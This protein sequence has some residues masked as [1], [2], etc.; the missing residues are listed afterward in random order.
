M[1]DEKTSLDLA[2]QISITSYENAMKRFDAIDNKIQ[3]LFTFALGFLVIT[4]SLIKPATTSLTCSFWVAIALLVVAAVLSVLARLYGKLHSLSPQT[5]FNECL[6]L[7]PDKFKREV[8]ESAGKAYDENKQM[9][10]T[11]WRLSLASMTIFGAGLVC[12]IYWLSRQM[13]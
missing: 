11:K 9:L 5:I 4:P 8:I 10:E 2:Y 6:A 1:A 3:N 12:L 7:E 13:A